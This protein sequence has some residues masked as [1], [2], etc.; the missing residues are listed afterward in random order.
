MA[1]S[2]ALHLIPR[3]RRKALTYIFGATAF[4]SILTVAGSEVLPCPARPSGNRRH[5]DGAENLEGV[6]GRTVIEKK[7]RRWIE[8]SRPVTSS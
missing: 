4:T 7:P 2:R 1:V 5:A 3:S 6:A 8:E